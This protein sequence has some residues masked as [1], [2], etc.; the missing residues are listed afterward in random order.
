MMSTGVDGVIINSNYCYYLVILKIAQ[1]C[2]KNSNIFTVSVQGNNS[3]VDKSGLT[4]KTQVG[5]KVPFYEVMKVLSS[6]PPF[7]SP[8]GRKPTDCFLWLLSTSVKV[9]M[10]SFPLMQMKLFIFFMCL[11]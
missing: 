6:P 10:S 11:S 2:N 3:Y 7:K 9:F 5:F 1:K 4:I 8:P